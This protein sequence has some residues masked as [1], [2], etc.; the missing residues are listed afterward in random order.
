MK[1]FF[2]G[3]SA[4][5]SS[6]SHGFANDWTVYVFESKAARD[7]FV[8]DSENLSCIAI[9]KKD[10]TKHARNL[11]LTSNG[12]SG[13]KPFTGEYWGIVPYYRSDEEIPGCIGIVDV[14]YPEGHPAGSVIDRLY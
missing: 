13:P 11:S 10:V 6:S 14:C 8:E 7:A 9:P 3:Q 1:R 2:A 4:N 5:G 12:Y